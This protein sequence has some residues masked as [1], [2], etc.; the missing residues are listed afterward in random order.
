MLL[1]E[2]LVKGCKEYNNAAQHAL[3]KKYSA[4]MKSVCFYYANAQE[5]AKDILHEGFIKVF[6]KIKNYDGNGSLEGWIRKIM[7]N[8]A[9]DY[10]KKKNPNIFQSLNNTLSSEYDEE[11]HYELKEDIDSDRSYTQEEL[12]EAISHLPDKY[13]IVFNMACLEDY[14]HKEIARL[15]SIKEDASR[16]RLK[17]ARQIL[18]EYLENVSRVKV[19]LR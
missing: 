10:I 1:E 17:R 5:D 9:I 6:T 4:Q 12:S 15:L 3:Y 18:C 13:R 11:P 7:V 19:A 8:T 16:T 14:S 2:E